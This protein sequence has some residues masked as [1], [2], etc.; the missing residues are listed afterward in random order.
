MRINRYKL[1]PNVTVETIP[2][3]GDGGT[4]I[5]KDC[6]KFVSKYFIIKTGKRRYRSSFDFTINIGFPDDLSNWNDFDY[7]LVLD[8]DFLQPYTPFYSLY[9]V[10]VQDFPVLERVI[11]MYNEYMDSLP[12]LEKIT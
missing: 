2:R 1:K 7:V 3:I 8:E 12:F 9:K 5:Q 4:W 11:K 6:V 10:D